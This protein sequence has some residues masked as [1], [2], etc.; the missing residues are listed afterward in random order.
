[1]KFIHRLAYYLFGFS[2]GLIFLFFFLSKKEASCDYSPNARVKKNIRIKPKIYSEAV[3]SK[4]QENA[5]DTSMVSV[6]LNKGKVDFSESNTNL[7]VCNIYTITGMVDNKKLKLKV[8][9][10][11]EE[12][13]ILLLSKI[14]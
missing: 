10:C 14:D 13:I 3:L 8:E 9:N 7:D 2:I 12:A 1:M 6:L 5:L 4:I 11:P